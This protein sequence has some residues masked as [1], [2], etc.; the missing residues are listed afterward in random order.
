MLFGFQHVTCRDPEAAADYLG[1]TEVHKESNA[2]AV[3]DRVSAVLQRGAASDRPQYLAVNF[4]EPHRP[5][6]W[7]GVAPDDERGVTV[8]GY[9][10]DRAGVRDDFAALQG[11]IGV[12][13]AAVGEILAAM[14]A[15]GGAEDT[16]FVFTTDHGLAMR[17]AKGT[18]FDAGIEVALMMRW[19]AGGIVG[20]RVVPDLVSNIDVLPT[21]LELIEVD[22][23]ATIQGK[24]F[25]T[26]TRGGRGSERTAVFG[27][28]T[29]HETYDPL[30]CIRTDRHK[31][32]A[33]FDT[34][35]FG[36]L[37][38]DLVASPTFVAAFEEI[39]P[40]FRFRFGPFE[41]Y[42]LH[43]DP[44]EKSNLSGQR[45]TA[46][47]EAELKKKLWAWMIDTNDPLRHGPIASPAHNRTIAGLSRNAAP[48]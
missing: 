15:S 36:G 21:L 31:L 45:E 23:P 1:F 44:F 40:D 46:D 28:K 14:D 8:P 43:D 30:R 11:A 29:F 19:P 4:F 22:G 7:G 18:L 13:D 12:M 42:D 39:V 48:S 32:I 17:R 41:L 35:A 25:A 10:P 47:L 37:P 20:G 6:D 16:I 38:T 5:Y 9:L 2:P 27:E 24:S 3:A 26:A 33:R 34:S